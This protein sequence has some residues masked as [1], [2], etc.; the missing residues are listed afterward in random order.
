MEQ[1]KF[2]EVAEECQSLLD[3][4]A[5]EN[6]TY[7]LIATDTKRVIGS[8]QGRGDVLVNAMVDI[9]GNSEMLNSLLAASLVFCKLNKESGEE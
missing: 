1:K 3:G 5:G 4:L 7:M 8:I 9:M 2:L 6:H